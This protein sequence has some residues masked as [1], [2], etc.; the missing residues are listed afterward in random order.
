MDYRLYLNIFLPVVK[1]VI[2][3]AEVDEGTVWPVH[4]VVYLHFQ[5]DQ[6]MVIEANIDIQPKFFIGDGFSKNDRVRNL[7]G[8]NFLIL[9]DAEES[10]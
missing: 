4:S 6:G 3:A 7:G 5:I 8:D 10:R 1:L 9:K 2:R